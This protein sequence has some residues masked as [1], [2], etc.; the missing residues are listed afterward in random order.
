MKKLGFSLISLF[1][2]F[3]VSCAAPRTR[4]SGSD[5]GT[6]RQYQGPPPSEQLQLLIDVPEGWLHLQK[7]PS[8][9]PGDLDNLV[10]NEKLQV[11]IKVG[12][13]PAAIGSPIKIATDFAAGVQKSGAQ[14]S[15]ITSAEDDN[16]ASFIVTTVSGRVGKVTIR[17]LPENPRFILI[18]AGHW[19]AEA[20]ALVLP[21]FDAMAAS[22]KLK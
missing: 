7:G 19:P 14:V 12:L 3:A 15:E 10:I 8:T 1:A 11:L 20:N 2:L 17:I 5:L 6:P 21:I 22:T 9:T 16:Q 4:A 13:L 18:F